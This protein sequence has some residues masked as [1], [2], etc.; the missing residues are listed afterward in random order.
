MSVSLLRMGRDECRWWCAGGRGYT[1]CFEEGGI[2]TSLSEAILRCGGS[3][4]EQCLWSGHSVAVEFDARCR[5]PR[6]RVITT[7]DMSQA[8]RARLKAYLRECF[9]CDPP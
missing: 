4:V 2:Y 5:K 1:D 7:F 9:G 8:Q 3:T 6:P